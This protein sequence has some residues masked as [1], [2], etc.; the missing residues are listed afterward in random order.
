MKHKSVVKIFWIIMATLMIVAMIG[1]T[2]AP[3][4]Y[5]Y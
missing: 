2:I 3:A 1:F 5:G 4:F